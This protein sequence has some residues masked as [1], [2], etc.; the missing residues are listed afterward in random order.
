MLLAHAGVPVSSF[1][2]AHRRRKGARPGSPLG[3]ANRH[4]SDFSFI[5]SFG[6]KIMFS[7]EGNESPP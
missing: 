1:T 4:K 2:W 6:T 3:R 7:V 5:L